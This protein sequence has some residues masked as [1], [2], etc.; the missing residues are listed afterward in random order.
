M[1]FFRAITGLGWDLPR[2]V[3]QLGCVALGLAGLCLLGFGAF[4]FSLYFNWGAK[5]VAYEWFSTREALDIPSHS[6]PCRG[7]SQSPSNPECYAPDTMDRRHCRWWLL[8]E[9][10]AF[11]MPDYILNDPAK[12]GKMLDAIMYPCPYLLALSRHK[13]VGSRFND[14]CPTPKTELGHY[15]ISIDFFGNGQHTIMRID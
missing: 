10:R 8:E 11:T 13:S 12:L 6:S 9:S 4:V 14:L 1:G 2:F 15:P 3:K 5:P 7:T